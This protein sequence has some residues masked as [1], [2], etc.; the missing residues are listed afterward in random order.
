MSERP[1]EAARRA[2]YQTEFKAQILN[3]FVDTLREAGHWAAVSRELSRPARSYCEEPRPSSTWFPGAIILEV[4]G[5]TAD[6]F[7]DGPLRAL[8]RRSIERSV[9]QTARTMIEGLTRVFGMTPA[10]LL[11]RLG[12]FGALTSRGVEFEW[13]SVEP[14]VG[15]LEIEYPH[16]RDLPDALF[17]FNAGTMDPVFDLCGVQGSLSAHEVLT[18]ERNRVR[19]VARWKAR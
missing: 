18:P 12:M 15:S 19:H 4:Q 9:M 6:L 8:G 3:A 17:V 2:H 1:G 5:V 11:G 13:R 10:S 7:G 16:S 14:N